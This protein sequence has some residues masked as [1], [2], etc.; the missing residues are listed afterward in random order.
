MSIVFVEYAIK[1]DFRE[2]FLIY[3]QQWQR[4]E[5]RLEVLEGTDQPG[6]FVEIWK[7][8]S[9]EEYVALKEERLRGAGEDQVQ[10]DAWIAGGLSKLHMWHFSPI[11]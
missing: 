11:A 6:L 4:R 7:G 10:W 8:M 1:P 9:H 2:P 5:G 3:M